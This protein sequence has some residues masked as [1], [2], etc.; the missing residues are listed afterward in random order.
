ML[1]LGP[2]LGCFSLLGQKDGNAKKVVSV[3]F[4]FWGHQRRRGLLGQSSKEIYTLQCWH[5][6]CLRSTG[7][8][9]KRNLQDTIC[10]ISEKLILALQFLK[11]FKCSITLE[12][13]HCNFVPKDYSSAV[14]R[15]IPY[16]CH[17]Q[18]GYSNFWDWLVSSVFM[19]M[20]IDSTLLE[21]VIS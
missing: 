11:T 12:I 10:L 13:L 8:Q 18:L 7:T 15:L 16:N 20:P 2:T 4:S 5:I 14:E 3:N 21:S 9:C 1:I 19:L 6:T 17:W